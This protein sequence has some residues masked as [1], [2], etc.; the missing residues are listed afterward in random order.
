MLRSTSIEV[1]AKPVE[2]EPDGSFRLRWTP[3]RPDLEVAIHAGSSP[4]A[5]DLE[6]PL[7]RTREREHRLG[8]V[9][10]S[11]RA[12]FALEAGDAEPLI[13]AE[14]GFALEGASNFRDFGGY[15]TADGH[16]VRWG[17]LYRSGELSG[18]SDRDRRFVASL[19]LEAIFDLR[20]PQEDERAPSA[21]SPREADRITHIPLYPGSAHAYREQLMAGTATAEG[22]A[23]VME[24]INRD[25]AREH[26]TEYGELLGRV[27]DAQ[28]PVLIH[29]AAGK[30][31][32]GFGVALLLLALGVPRETVMVDYLLS[33]EFFD[34]DRVLSGERA[35][36]LQRGAP[37]FDPAILRPLVEARRNYLEAG[38]A[39][40]DE[41][42]DSLD[43]YLRGALRLSDTQLSRLRDRLLE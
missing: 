28:G 1:D 33:R 30:D 32:T 42:A 4:E 26:Q 27:A 17:Q 20:I 8:P 24:A 29:C 23:D 31:R 22:L 6:R 36:Y 18:L 9:H 5:V 21:L 39:A 40:V 14:R 7:V 16:R 12:F 25:L 10:V 13:V 41:L 2:R 34:A 37:A 19:G 38:L 3:R 15:S 43:A 35:V 11:T